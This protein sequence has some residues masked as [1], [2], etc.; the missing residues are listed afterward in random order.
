MSAA[1]FDEPA[2][3]LDVETTGGDPAFHRVIEIGL[4][5][6]AGGHCIGEWSTLLN[7]GRPIPHG[8]QVLTGI[9]DT[10]VGTAPTF[11]EIAAALHERLAGKLLVAHNA[12]FDYGFLRHEFLRAG[13]RYASRVL[14]TVRLSRKLFPHYPRHNLDSLIVRYRLP[15]EDR[16][17]ALGDARTLRLLAERWRDELDAGVLSSAVAHQLEAPALPPRAPRELAAQIE[18]TRNRRRKV[19]EGL[20]WHWRP[21]EPEPPRLARAGEIDPDRLDDFYGLFRSRRA[22]V[23]ALR[24]LSVAY[25][26]CLVAL[27]LES[28]PGSCSAHAAGRCD[29]ACAGTQPRL[30]H[31]MRA[32]AALSRLRLRRWPFR[33]RIAV[34]E[35]DA[36][37][38][39]MLDRWCYLGTA[40]S[41]DELFELS[42]ADNAPRFDLDIYRILTR[43]LARPRASYRVIELARQSV[44]T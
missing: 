1:L 33:G 27:G 41:E 5:E 8:I 42:A 19:D 10:M 18:E 22:A 40:R 16:H 34:R 26:L 39:V 6:V 15:G 44:T 17:R 35:R 37:S 32:T 2:V 14:C 13:L 38:V 11:A 31:A 29:G 36:E 7:P 24:N 3:L 4:V 30:T 21:E 25:R 23:E 20:S 28:G 9:T 12:R 43:F